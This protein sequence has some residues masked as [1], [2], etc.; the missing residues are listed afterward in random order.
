MRPPNSTRRVP[1]G[2][3]VARAEHAGVRVGK[4]RSCPTVDG[5]ENAQ[6]VLKRCGSDAQLVAERVVEPVDDQQQ[7]TEQ[8]GDRAG[9]QPA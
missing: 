4:P 3:S 6:G 1:Y 8:D 7:Q 2:D 9:E 5:V